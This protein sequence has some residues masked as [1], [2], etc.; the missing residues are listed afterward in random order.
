MENVNALLIF[1]DLQTELVLDNVVLFNSEMQ[2]ETVNVLKDIGK[3]L[4][5]NV[6]ILTALQELFGMQHFKIVY[7]FAMFLKFILMVL[8]NVKQGIKKIIHMENASLIVD[9]IK[10]EWMDSANVLRDIKKLVEAF[11]FWIVLLEVLI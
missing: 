4:L 5:D 3:I 6:N 10:W 7:P 11:V 2:M 9:I 8:V 1:R